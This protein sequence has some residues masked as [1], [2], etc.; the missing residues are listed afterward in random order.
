MVSVIDGGVEVVITLST[1]LELF[2]GVVENL[3]K[4]DVDRHSDQAIDDPVDSPRSHGSGFADLNIVE[5]GWWSWIKKG[6]TNDI[7]AHEAHDKNGEENAQCGN[8]PD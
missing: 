7:D 1:V 6:V 3:D 4:T 5:T 8:S 2:P